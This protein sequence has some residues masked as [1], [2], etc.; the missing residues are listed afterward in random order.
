[1]V[2]VNSPP[3]IWRIKKLLNDDEI[4]LKSH[5]IAMNKNHIWFIF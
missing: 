5:S 2:P 3:S 4:A 1:M